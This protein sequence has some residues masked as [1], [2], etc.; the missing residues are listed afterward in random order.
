[1][2]KNTVNSIAEKLAKFQA[3]CPPIKKEADNPFYKSSYAELSEIV[4]VT[5]PVL[6]K[7]GLVVIQPIVDGK[8]VTKLMSTDTSEVIESSYTIITK[9]IND[10]QKYGAGVTYARRYGYTAML[11]IV[12]EEDDDGNT[13]S[14][15]PEIK[16]ITSVQM[17]TGEQTA[18]IIEIM[19]KK[20]S[21]ADKEAKKI[22]WK[23]YMD[24]I[25]SKATKPADLTFD[26]ADR[27]LTN[28]KLEV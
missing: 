25:N 16:K 11:G 9:D 4:K 27:L 8:V 12:A 24:G 18:Q 6:H 15:K 26:E 3:L 17:A 14:A 20:T 23:H 21:G 22:A 5:M 10:P 2:E 1:M 7:C 19:S 13:A 28:L